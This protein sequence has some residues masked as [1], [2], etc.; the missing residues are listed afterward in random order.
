M[1]SRPSPSADGRGLCL[2]GPPHIGKRRLL[3]ALGENLFHA[4]F[5]VG[6]ISGPDF[7]NPQNLLVRLKSRRRDTMA[8]ITESVLRT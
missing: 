6:Q 7:D 1:N 5:Q 3:Y 2:V 4:G 8:A